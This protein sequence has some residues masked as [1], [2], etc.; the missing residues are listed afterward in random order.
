MNLTYIAIAIVVIIVGA[1]AFREWRTRDKLTK[2][3]VDAKAAFDTKRTYVTPADDCPRSKVSKMIFNDNHV[4]LTEALSGA[5]IKIPV[6]TA[7]W[8]QVER[9]WRDGFP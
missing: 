7:T 5:L 9:L 8:E 2:C 6:S 4:V 3:L 1:L